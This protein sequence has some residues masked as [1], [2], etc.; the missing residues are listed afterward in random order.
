TV[1]PSLARLPA[2]LR[3]FGAHAPNTAS[4]RSS[5]PFGPSFASASLGSDRACTR[6][7]DGPPCIEL[8]RHVAGTV[9]V[10]GLF[11]RWLVCAKELLRL[12]LPAPP[13]QGRQARRDSSLRKGVK[14]RRGVKQR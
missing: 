6:A 2:Q 9:R 7:R 12:C 5:G 13:Y 4:A 8:M 1:G 3:R 14:Q 10:L 11:A